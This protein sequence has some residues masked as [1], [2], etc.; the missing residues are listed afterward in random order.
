MDEA[1]DEDLLSALVERARISEAEG[2]H[3]ADRLIV[4]Y[5]EDSRLHFLRGSLLAAAGR[6]IE[7]HAAL[8]RAVALAPD[9]ALARFQLGLFELTSGEADRALAT[10]QPLDT[11]PD[12]HYLRLFLVGL[13][14]LIRD[15][16]K[17][18]IVW[19]GEGI[20]A[21][22]ENLPLNRDM[23]LLIDRCREADQAPRAE[24]TTEISATSVL[25]DQFGVGTVH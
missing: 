9:F 14:H 11:L 10:W 3:E 2:L 7:A 20:A 4:D 21:N 12:R 23:Q 24:P 17:D 5:P 1:C 13:R 22:T 8:S 25:L 15:E 19:L 6:A 16:F 18:A